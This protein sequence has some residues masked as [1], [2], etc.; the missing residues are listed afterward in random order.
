VALAQ[1]HI[2]EAL[3]RADDDASVQLEAGNIAALSGDETAA[4]AAWERAAQIAPD[5]EQGAAARAALKQ[6]DA[7]Q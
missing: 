4:K 5:R 3:S 7:P 2:K 6:F 1:R